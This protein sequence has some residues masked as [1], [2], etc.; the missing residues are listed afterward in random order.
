VE[1]CK[2]LVPGTSSDAGG[3]RGQ[4]PVP[5]SPVSHQPIVSGPGGPGPGNTVQVDP[6]K[7]TLKAPA[8]KHLTLEYDK[9]L[10]NVGFKFNL[11]RYTQATQSRWLMPSKPTCAASDPPPCRTSW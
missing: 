4:I 11:R 1:E 2:P 8:T 6:I 9:L 5:R 3:S 10:S 7:P